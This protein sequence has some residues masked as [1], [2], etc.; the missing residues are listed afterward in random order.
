MLKLYK[1]IA[2]DGGQSQISLP[3]ADDLLPH[4]RREDATTICK[5]SLK[6]GW[7]DHDIGRRVL[8]IDYMDY[9]WVKKTA[10]N[11]SESATDDKENATQ[12]YAL[13]PP[14]PVVEGQ[15]VVIVHRNPAVAE[16][17]TMESTTRCRLVK[18]P[19]TSGEDLFMG[20]T[21]PGFLFMK[22]SPT[23]IDAQEYTWKTS[24]ASECTVNEFTL[25]LRAA[26]LDK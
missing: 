17:V 18:C 26:E 2:D 21:S 7:L 1:L 11:R 8:F 12:E 14:P 24:H 10:P 20:P 3:L 19:P 22:V 6:P 23:E 15:T 9:L 13:Y 4:W 5:N 16:T 25:P